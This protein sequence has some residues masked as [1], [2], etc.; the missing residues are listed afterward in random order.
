MDFVRAVSYPYSKTEYT[1]LMRAI[2]LGV[3]RARE[4]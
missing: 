2:V 1:E 3:M 4:E